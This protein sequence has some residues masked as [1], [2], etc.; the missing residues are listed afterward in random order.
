MEE[1]EA[2]MKEKSTNFKGQTIK[3]TDENMVFTDNPC[4]QEQLNQNN[5]SKKMRIDYLKS[6]EDTYFHKIKVSEA[7]NEKLNKELD[8]AYERY[9]KLNEYAQLLRQGKKLFS[10]AE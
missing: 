6:V 8:A 10:E 5:E 3:D 4:K 2:R 9:E 1:K 7:N